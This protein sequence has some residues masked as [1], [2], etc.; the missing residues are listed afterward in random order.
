MEHETQHTPQV[1]EIIRNVPLTSLTS[2]TN[3]PADL[4]S[5]VDA[6]VSLGARTVDVASVL[7]GDD[8]SV[9]L[10]PSDDDDAWVPT[11]EP[12]VN[13]DAPAPVEQVEVEFPNPDWDG[14]DEY[15]DADED[16]YDDTQAYPQQRTGLL[17]RFRSVFGKGLSFEQE[18]AQIARNRKR[19]AASAPHNFERAV[20]TTR[21][22]VLRCRICGGPSPEVG[23]ICNGAVGK[24]AH[25][26][27]EYSGSYEHEHDHGADIGDLTVRSALLA[28]SIDAIVES[29]GYFTPDEAHYM[30]PSPFIEEHLACANCVA[31]CPETAGCYW[32]DGAI[33]PE[34]ICRLWVIPERTR[35]L[36]PEETLDEDV[37]MSFK[38]EIIEVDGEYCVTSADGNQSFGC[39]ASMPEAEDRLL[40][41]ERF[42]K[43][44]MYTPPKGVQEEAQRAVR[45]IEDGEAGNNF[46]PV[47]RRRASDLAAGRPVSIDIIRR[48]SSYLAR[49]AV[50]KQGQGFSPGEDGYPSA[51]R[52]AWAAWGGDPAIAWTRSIIDS[53]EK[54]PTV[55]DVH[56]DVPM[57]SSRR[58]KKLP[59][60]S[61]GY[62]MKEIGVGSYVSWS[63]SGGRARGRVE[64]VSTNRP[65]PVPDSSFTIDASEDDPAVLIRLWEETSEGW[66]QTD[67]RVGHRLSTLTE[68]AALERSASI[69]SIFS[70]ADERRYTLGPWY[71]PDAYDAHGEW[72]DPEQLQQALW[73][74]VRNSDRQIRLQH[75]LEVVAGEWVEALTW[76]MPV[77]VPMMDADGN[78]T[79]HEFPAGTVYMGVVWEPW[80]WELV[81]QGKIRGYSIGGRGE[82]VMI[83]LE[84]EEGVL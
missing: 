44:E 5:K 11:T 76:P 78:V 81:R 77:V 41:I 68:I 34:G 28:S 36:G 64:R 29:A 6:M 50:D 32:V 60:L 80:A 73:D 17:D 42:K 22:G 74:Y 9:V 10:L 12:E 84:T 39:Y 59:S 40:Q 37:E 30:E 79:D 52:V 56:V 1:I 71:V 3:L 49:H 18:N 23:D 48:M 8:Y 53:V 66:R 67:R 70:K 2:A 21:K 26:S 20:W 47:G 25:E 83:D 45:W 72:T 24:M 14:G 35:L 62:M 38:K 65:I 82:R 33:M 31:Y 7:T 46:T 55:N 69:P 43:A 57:G 51:G 27:Y 4:A 54:S 19:V 58:T 75:N 16:E 61:M 63:S 13:D 15:A